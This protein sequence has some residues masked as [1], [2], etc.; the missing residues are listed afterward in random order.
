MLKM[1]TGSLRLFLTPNARKDLDVVNGSGES[2]DD[3]SMRTD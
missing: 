2:W 3:L 1:V